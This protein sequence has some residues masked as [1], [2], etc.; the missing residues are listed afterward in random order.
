MS[1]DKLAT[2]GS[3]L[4]DKADAVQL[5]E[6]ATQLKKIEI[7]IFKVPE[8]GY[9]RWALDLDPDQEKKGGWTGETS[10]GADLTEKEKA[11]ISELEQ[12]TR[13]RLEEV[14]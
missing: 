14:S 11:R 7:S 10:F 5:A 1:Q 4:L 6:K 2:L 13:V 12:D 9:S 3:A 8:L